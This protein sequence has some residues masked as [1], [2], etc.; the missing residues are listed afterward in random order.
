MQLIFYVYIY[1]ILKI[2]IILDYAFPYLSI[3]ISMI[4]NAIHY[5]MKLDQTFKSLV[6]RSV[7]EVKNFVIICKLKLLSLTLILCS[8][9]YVITTMNFPGMQWLLLAY[10]IISLDHHY[11]LL[12]LVPFP[13]I[14][15]IMTVRFTDP[16]E[17]REPEVCSN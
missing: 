1:I 3:A 4:A 15:Y 11:I 12:C 13:S 5:S 9:N 7:I 6:I 17:F 14:F 2:I 10:G 8:E 16:A